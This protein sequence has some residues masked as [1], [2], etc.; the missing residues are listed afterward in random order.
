MT[1]DDSRVLLEQRLD[2][3]CAEHRRALQAL[4]E[5]RVVRN[6]AVADARAGGLTWERIADHFGV[7]P[8][9]PIAWMHRANCEGG[10]GHG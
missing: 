1:D 2:D 6:A 8:T 4:R 3:A 5:A 10:H 7:V 9:A